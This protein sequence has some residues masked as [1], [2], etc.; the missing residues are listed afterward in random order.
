MT[1]FAL[2]L[3]LAAIIGNSALAQDSLC[4]AHSPAADPSLYCFPLLPADRAPEAGGTAVLQ[5]DASPFGLAVSRDGRVRFRVRLT[6]AGLPDPPSLGSY[7]SFVAWA[8]TPDLDPMISLGRVRNGS[9]VVG[10]IQLERF[11]VL[12]S[13]ERRADVRFPTGPFVLR[14]SSPSLFM[15]PHGVTELPPATGPAHGHAMGGW[16]MPPMHPTASRMPYGLERFRPSV[17]PFLPAYRG[18]SLPSALPS[19]SYTLADGD[20]I[21]LTAGKVSRT[22]GKHQLVTYAYNGQV[23]GPRLEIPQ[24]GTVTVRFRNNTDLPGSIHWHGLRLANPNDGV[25]GLTQPPVA[26]G[27]EFVYRVHAPDA[28][29][30]WYHPHH[31]QDLTQDLGL[32]GNIIVRGRADVPVLSEAKKRTDGRRDRREAFLV[33]DDL[34]ISDGGLMPYGREAATHALMGRFGNVLLVNGAE[35]WK[36]ESRPGET[37]R[38]HLTNAA[39]ARTFNLSLDRISLRVMEGD[40]GPFAHPRTVESVVIAPAERYVV[41]ATPKRPGRY[42]LVNR[43]RGIDRVTGRFFA[44][45]DTMGVLTVRGPRARRVGRAPGAGSDK[46]ASL[47]QSLRGTKPD[48]TLQLSLRT[49]GLPFALIQALRLDTSYVHPV[50]WT[51]PMP[52]MD[53]LSTGREVSWIIRDSASG[54]EGMA[55]DWRVPRGKPLVVRLVNDKHVLHPMGH[56]IHLHG[57]RFLVL[58]QNGMPNENPVWKDTV[59]VPAGGTVDLLIDASNPGR[60]MLHC[61]IAEHLESGM[62]TVI[63]IE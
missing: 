37:V 22:I 43:V 56:P 3:L 17:T 61:H 48:R 13:A 30:F 26:P 21:T 47:V 18:A 33:L 45:V 8:T 16:A 46:L 50:E 55:L 59:L 57:Q 28:G 53:W 1:S 9:T 7:D 20:T 32:A 58:A 52:M 2:S 31:R 63:T 4:A 41:E 40:V 62:H 5:P 15:A 36:F 60:W 38:L 12:I 42:N 35:D 11:M 44:E 25:P 24:G 14:G 6:L 34:L 39:S 29:L 51:S 23:P 54:S 10:P 19:R 49:Q 27:G